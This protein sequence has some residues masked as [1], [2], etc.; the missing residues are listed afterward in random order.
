MYAGLSPT[1]SKADED[2]FVI[3]YGGLGHQRPDI[4]ESARA[5]EDGGNSVALEFWEWCESMTSDYS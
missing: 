1:L 4:E 3:P 2:K 5:V